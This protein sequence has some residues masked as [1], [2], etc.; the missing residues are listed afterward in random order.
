MRTLY[1]ACLVLFAF[2]TITKRQAVTNSQEN[3]FLHMM[4]KA[5][6][7]SFLETLHYE[8]ADWKKPISRANVSSLHL[9]NYDEGK[10]IEQFQTTC[11]SDLDGIQSTINMLSLKYTLTGQ[12]DLLYRLADFRNDLNEFYGTIAIRAFPERTAR[13]IPLTREWADGLFA[14]LKELS[15]LERQLHQHVVA[16]AVAIDLK[17]EVPSL[18]R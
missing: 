15:P 17:F 13:D 7:H 12:V 3:P 9:I 11:L 5:E 6:L 2:P 8:A 1:C 10:S 16:M 18:L 4:S 14:V